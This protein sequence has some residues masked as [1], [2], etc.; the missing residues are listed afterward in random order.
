MGANLYA[1]DQLAI[2]EAQ[3]NGHLEVVEYLVSMGANAPTS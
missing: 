1:D 3:K 2:K